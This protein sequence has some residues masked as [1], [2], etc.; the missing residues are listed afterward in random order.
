MNHQ[1]KY[2][3]NI[4]TA[5]FWKMCLNH[6]TRVIPKARHGHTQFDEIST[7]F[8][9]SILIEI[10]MVMVLHMIHF[11]CMLLYIIAEFFR[12]ISKANG[13]RQTPDFRSNI[14]LTL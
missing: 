1:L 4:G 3:A 2:F 9:P 13:Y 10:G 14:S 12:T 8:R 6:R 11:Y 5:K 7:K